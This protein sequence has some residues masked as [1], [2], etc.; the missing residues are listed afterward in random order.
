MPI[1]ARVE[2]PF[3]GAV[4]LRHAG[5]EGDDRRFGVAHVVGRGWRQCPQPLPGLGDDILDHPGDEPADKLVRQAACIERRLFSADTL[6]E[7]AV[8][9]HRPRDIC[10]TQSETGFDFPDGFLDNVRKSNKP[11]YDGIVATIPS[12]RM[13]KPEEVAELV[14]FLA[15]DR[16]AYITGASLDINGGDLMV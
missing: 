16:S 9:N 13:G 14:A 1:H 11:M 7:F 2:E 15:S 10:G 6:Q 5:R 3:D 12:G 4:G 8:M